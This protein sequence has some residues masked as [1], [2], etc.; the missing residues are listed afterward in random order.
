MRREQRNF[1][2]LL[3]VTIFMALGF[4]FYK[5][6]VS[7]RLFGVKIIS[8]DKLEKKIEDR[9]EMSPDSS[10]LFVNGN[11]VAYD[12]N[13]NRVFIAQD[14]SEEKWTG[15]IS[16]TGGNLYFVK[17]KKGETKS[18]SI[19]NG[20]EHTLVY[21]GKDDYF[22]TKVVVSGMPIMTLDTWYD[23]AEE[24]WSGAMQLFDPSQTGNDYQSGVC[25]FSVRGNIARLYDKKSYK[26]TL[27]D[28]KMSLCGLRKDD[29]WTLNGLYDDVGLIRNKLS[30]QLWNE[31]SASNGVNDDNTVETAFLELLVD[32]EYKGVY[33]LCDRI[34]SKKLNLSEGD[35]LYKHKNWDKKRQNL[36][37]SFIV[38]Y[39]NDYNEEEA[40]APMV[41]LMDE[42]YYPDDYDEAY[43]SFSKKININNAVDYYLYCMYLAAGDNLFENS[44]MVAKKKGNGYEFFEIPWDMNAT[45]GNIRVVYYEEKIEETDNL[46]S[47]VAKTLLNLKGEDFS[48]KS[49]QRWRELRATVLSDENVKELADQYISYTVDSGAFDRN[50]E[51]WPIYNVNNSDSYRDMGELWNKEDMFNYIEKRGVFLD[52]YYSE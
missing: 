34:D 7:H 40:K 9:V 17:D 36:A 2:I 16:C 26:L 1:I 3:L 11:T 28:E 22:T 8:T 52:S 19:A 13:D 35:Y 14:L 15:K 45:F 4:F 44:Y 10:R 31:M 20:E 5:V 18:Q 12:K 23:V 24:A 50:L 21:I 42:M 33:L 32:G 27:S 37:A 29:D 38:S 43:D 46:T 30:Y 41:D 39:P 47:L 48:E 51:R 25:N 6:E 49:A